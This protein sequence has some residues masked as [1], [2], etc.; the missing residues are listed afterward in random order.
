MLEPLTDHYLNEVL[1]PHI[2]K[3]AARRVHAA[4]VR[5]GIELN[6]SRDE[7]AELVGDVLLDGDELEPVSAEGR[8]AAFVI[9]EILAEARS[10]QSPDWALDIML[11]HRFLYGDEENLPQHAINTFLWLKKQTKTTHRKRRHGRRGG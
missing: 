11:Y 8:I 4:A 3:D 2:V 5:K 1:R 9:D 6:G 10:G 7:L